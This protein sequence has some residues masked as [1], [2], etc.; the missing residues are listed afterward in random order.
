M[1]NGEHKALTRRL[2]GRP[3]KLADPKKLAR[4]RALYNGGQ[5]DGA[6]L[7]VSRAT[8]YRDRP[9]AEPAASE[10]GAG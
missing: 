7:G 8:L 1:S 5:A 2:G 4:A 10:D 9:G 6:T 3:K